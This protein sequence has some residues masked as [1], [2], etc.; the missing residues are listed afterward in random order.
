MLILC[1]L[2][3][4]LSLLVWYLFSDVRKL[5]KE[6]I[7]KMLEEGCDFKK[8]SLIERINVFN[9]YKRALT[10][11][12]QEYIKDFDYI[13]SDEVLNC[14]YLEQ[15]KI[16][17]ILVSKHENKLLELKGKNIHRK[18]RKQIKEELHKLHVIESARNYFQD[19]RKKAH[20]TMKRLEPNGVK[21]SSYHQ[22]YPKLLLKRKKYL[23]KTIVQIDNVCQFLSKEKEHIENVISE[24]E[25]CKNPTLWNIIGK[26]IT[27]PVR[28]PVNLTVSIL[29]GD[30]KGSFIHGT[31]TALMLFGVG[32]VGDTLDIFDTLFD[33]FDIESVDR[34]FHHVDSHWV[35]GYA[36]KD[37]TIVDGYYRGGE[38][39]YFQS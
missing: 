12:N 25:K 29:K 32:I 33:G 8:Y 14:E 17:E 2:L 13:T 18:A 22:L 26:V 21:R 19:H 36:K 27:A 30:I 28:H 23:L 20:R 39:G 34:A 9:R 6:V 11:F 5:S 16:S 7:E 3:S 1:I 24:L 38:D 37:G 15:N 31:R 4:I 35:E 10:E